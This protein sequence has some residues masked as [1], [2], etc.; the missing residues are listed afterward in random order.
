MNGYRVQAYN[1]AHSSENKI[2][3][4]DVARRFGFSGALVPGVDVYAYMMHLPVARWGRAFLERGTA[5]C[6]FTTPV[7][8]GEIAEVAGREGDGGDGDAISIEVTSGGKSCA[9]GSARLPADAAAPPSP[10]RYPTA[11]PPVM[12]S[13]PAASPATLPVGGILGTIPFEA[14][15]ELVASYLRDVRETDD[16][17]SREGLVHPGTVLRMC[18]LALLQNVLLGPWIHVG[19]VIQNFGAARAGETMT[20]RSSVAANYERKGHLFVELDVLVLSGGTRPV[21]QVRHTAIYRPRQLAE[22]RT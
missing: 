7:Y 22:N 20:A 17:Y 1:T 12:E 19:S 16:L 18:N 13:R 11:K 5:Q 14:S 8:D 10:D 9:T 15:A 2:H 3:D 6:R 21:A 4:D